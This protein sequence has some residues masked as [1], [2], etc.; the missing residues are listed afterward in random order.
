[1]NYYNNVHDLRVVLLSSKNALHVLLILVNLVSISTHCIYLPVVSLL[2]QA[3]GIKMAGDNADQ[4]TESSKSGAKNSAEGSGGG[5]QP[6]SHHRASN[7]QLKG[8]NTFA[9]PRT[10]R[11]L[12]W[13]DK[14]QPKSK[15]SD[16]VEDENPKSNDEFRKMFIKS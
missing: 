5:L 3:E 10:V 16:S 2:T 7:I 15:E 12:G 9:M 6:S 11:P 8:K 1:M 13:V 14:D 4:T